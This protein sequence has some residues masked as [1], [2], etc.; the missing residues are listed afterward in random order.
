MKAF[1]VILLILLLVLPAS[2]LSVGKGSGIGAV[3]VNVSAAPVVS[4][5]PQRTITVTVAA[6]APVIP[7]N[8]RQVVTRVTTAP[9][10][11]GVPYRTI[12]LVTTTQTISPDLRRTTAPAGQ[13]GTPTPVP[14]PAPGMAELSVNSLPPAAAVNIDNLVFITTNST[15]N[16]T[17]GTRNL[18]ISKTN[19]FP[20]V[21][22]RSLAAGTTTSITAFLSTISP[23][24]PTIPP[25]VARLTVHTVPEGGWVSMA[26]LNMSAP[27]TADLLPGTWSVTAS[28]SGYLPHT[29][30]VPDLAGGTW[31]TIYI[32]LGPVQ[33]PQ[34]NAACLSGQ[35]CL[36]P[37]EAAAYWPGQWWYQTSPVCDYAVEG[38]QSVPRY[39]TQGAS[40]QGFTLG[41]VPVAVPV[42]LSPG[43]QNAVPAVSATIIPRVQ[44][45]LKQGGVVES[46]FSFFGSLFGR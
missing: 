40:G 34:G 11:S 10:L 39:C 16:L 31:Q 35:Q 4:V 38:S 45:T 41:T 8:A 26:N 46:V 18:V 25:S 13:R 43:G 9:A 20:Y 12:T 7:T 14:T 3:K 42:S 32:N 1:L 28:K 6:T 44:E 23:L 22:T 27:M 37:A 33:N 5:A 30:S 36:T 17:P 21:E 2:A 15:V 24:E 19:Y 29:E